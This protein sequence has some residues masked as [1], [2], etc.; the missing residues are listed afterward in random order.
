MRRSRS[1]RGRPHAGTA[2]STASQGTV[3]EALTKSLS[4]PSSA[5][6]PPKTSPPQTLSPVKTKTSGSSSRMACWKKAVPFA[7]L[8][9]YACCALEMSVQKRLPV[10]W[11]SDTSTI[12]KVPCA[13]AEAPHNK[14][15]RR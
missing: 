3:L 11:T 13:H 7:S 1:E 6:W 12:L 9:G 14:G 5:F 2:P 8:H 4:R 15:E 10:W